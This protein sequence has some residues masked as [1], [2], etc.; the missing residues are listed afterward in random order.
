MPMRLE[1]RDA[2]FELRDTRQGAYELKMVED[3]TPAKK[4]P[5]PVGKTWSAKNMFAPKMGQPFILKDGEKIIVKTGAVLK[6]TG[7]LM[8]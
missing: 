8:E 1:T 2:V 4:F 7:N 3:L 6:V 5:A